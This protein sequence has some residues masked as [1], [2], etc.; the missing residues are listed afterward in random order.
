[1][2]L[3]LLSPDGA[4]DA[5]FERVAD[6][7]L[8]ALAFGLAAGVVL[9]L[10]PAAL[11]A[12]PAVATVMSPAARRD[13]AS[14]RSA[15]RGAPAVASFV[16]G[17][18]AP[19]AVAGYFFSSIAVLLSRASVVLSLLTAAVLAAAGVRMLS[20]ASRQCGPRRDVP[21]HPA[22]AAAYGVVFGVT[23]C[24]AC[25][26]LLIGLGSAVALAAGPAAAAL[27]LASFLVGRTAVLLV[28][29]VLG[30]RLLRRSGG[31]R[32]FDRLVGLALLA[33]AGYYAYLVAT[34]RVSAKPPGTPGSTLLP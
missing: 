19:L 8:A 12:L 15:L 13:G 18:D 24:S 20:R 2:T 33:A 3:A 31:E 21:P 22:D 11:P 6:G 9:G 10:S 30:G 1:M 32:A 27:V 17:M 7:G 16:V 28:A 29:A 5:A 14:W 23:A 34:G 4:L 26:P 25:A